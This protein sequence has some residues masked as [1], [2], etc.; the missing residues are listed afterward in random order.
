MMECESEIC[1]ATAI[2]RLTCPR[3]PPRTCLCDACLSDL[4][5]YAAEYR[6]VPGAV[7][8]EQMESQ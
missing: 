5:E 7:V 4:L 8:T 2:A 3:L 6:S 1:S